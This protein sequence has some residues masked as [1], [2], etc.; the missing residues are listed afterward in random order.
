[1]LSINTALAQSLI[2][3]NQLSDS[4]KVLV[5]HTLDWQAA[6]DKANQQLKD[7]ISQ[8]AGG[9]GQD[10]SDSL[11]QRRLKTELM[12]PKHLRVLYRK[13]YRQLFSS[14]SLIKYLEKHLT[15][16][17]R[18]F[19]HHSRQEGIS[20][21]KMICKASFKNRKPSTTWHLTLDNPYDGFSPG[22]F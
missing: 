14:C 12:Q 9:S 16:C 18:N 5:Q 10:L 13:R 7:V 15:I 17:S 19:R 21:G 6:I 2:A 3:N 8:L 20:I 1:V 22:H 11:V 4:T